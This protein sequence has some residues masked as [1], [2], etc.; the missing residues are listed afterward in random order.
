MK[1][2]ETVISDLEKQ[3]SAI[4]RALEALRQVG[5]QPAAAQRRVRPPGT[6]SQLTPAKPAAKKRG[7]KRQISPEGKKRIAEAAR[8]RWAEIRAAKAAT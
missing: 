5:G 3:R 6:K 8:R 1:N 7:G 4:E 2:I